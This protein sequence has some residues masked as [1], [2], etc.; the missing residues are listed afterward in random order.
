[1]LWSKDGH[2]LARTKL[3]LT[4]E[5]VASRAFDKRLVLVVDSEAHPVAKRNLCGQ[6]AGFNLHAA[7]KVGA[8]EA[9]TS[10]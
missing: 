4:G 9:T 7:T 3:A 1:M 8:N 5:V 6:H 10:R 2:E